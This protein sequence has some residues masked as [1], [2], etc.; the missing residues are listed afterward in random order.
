MHHESNFPAEVPSQKAEYF[1]TII[2]GL[3]ISEINIG[4][5][6]WFANVSTE[7]WRMSVINRP[8]PRAIIFLKNSVKINTFSIIVLDNEI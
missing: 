2:N 3:P 7:D 6:F 5:R 4:T 1:T 8:P